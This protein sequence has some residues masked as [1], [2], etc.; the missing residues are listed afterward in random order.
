MISSKRLF[1]NGLLAGLA[2]L[3]VLLT[4]PAL[5]SRQAVA[6]SSGNAEGL[7]RPPE[8]PEGY[9]ITPFGYFHRSCVRSVAEGDTL[10]ADGRI[11]HADGTVDLN[12]PVCGYPHYSPDGSVALESQGMVEKCTPT[13]GGSWI[14]SIGATTLTSYGELSATWTVPPS[15]ISDDNQLLYFF[16]G[17]Q[18]CPNVV[19]I[20][21]PV[22]QW[23][24]NNKFGGN[25]WVVASWNCCM[26]GIV[27]HS[28]PLGVNVGDT[29]L[30]AITPT[31]RSGRNCPTWN[32]VSEDVT[33]GWKTTLAKTSANGQVWNWAFGAVLEVYN[34]VQCSDYPAN[35]ELPF[36]VRLYDQNL[37]LIA[38]PGWI[39]NPA[40]S[41]TKPKCDYG[42]K[43]TR[44]TETIKYNTGV[45]LTVSL[46]GTGT[47][48]VVSSPAGI[49]CPTVC[50]ARF[51][52]GTQVTLTETPGSGTAFIQWSGDCVGYAPMTQVT[53]NPNTNCTA[54]FTNSGFLQVKLPDQ[55]G[56][57]IT[58]TFY[59]YPALSGS[60]TITQTG[61]FP[62][63]GLGYNSTYLTLLT[64]KPEAKDCYYFT[65][66][67]QD[68][69]LV[70]SFGPATGTAFET[71]VA[72]LC[73][74]GYPQQYNFYVCQGMQ[75]C[76]PPVRNC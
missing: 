66:G 60:V 31:C 56:Y 27:W 3:V 63:N 40:P 73:G 42:V 21:Q 58:T 33:T 71:I 1:N 13:T 10:L 19:S 47:D 12:A 75:S 55:A 25:Y 69:V 9:V 59:P 68:F 51:A 18:D 41:G 43:A 72:V 64:C 76:P 7:N 53:A 37:K 26:K 44:T 24:K 15:P 20:L 30:G 45:K 57:Q 38:N 74:Q 48:T 52:S 54:N 28:T 11:Q 29:I 2:G 17:F 39:G 34:V 46:G 22:L 67:G 4:A 49:N 62:N 65:N 16:P 70:D 5:L 35:L 32:V 14:E 50:T 36:T 61:E 23:G 6:S 8:V